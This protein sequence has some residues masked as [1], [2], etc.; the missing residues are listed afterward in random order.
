MI[1]DE[2]AQ[3]YVVGWYQFLLDCIDRDSE[4]NLEAEAKYI[5]DWYLGVIE[6][7]FIRET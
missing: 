5:T 2:Q 6:K 3:A 7:V 1:T 4:Q